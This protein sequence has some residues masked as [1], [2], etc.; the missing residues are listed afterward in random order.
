MEL[1]NKTGGP[2]R[3]IEPKNICSYEYIYIYYVFPSFLNQGIME[4]MGTGTSTE[5]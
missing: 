3:I 4:E 5:S 1:W 2:T